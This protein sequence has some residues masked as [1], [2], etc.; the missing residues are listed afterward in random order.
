MK[1]QKQTN[2][3]VRTQ[4]QK[5]EGDENAKIQIQKVEGDENVETQTQKQTMMRMHEHKCKSK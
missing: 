3:D 5:I 2:E 4:T 1:T